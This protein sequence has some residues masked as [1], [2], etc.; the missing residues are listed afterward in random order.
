MARK[1]ESSGI[2]RLFL[3]PL[4]IAILAAG[5][6]PWWW[7]EVK[8]LLKPQGLPIQVGDYQLG[9]YYIGIF[10]RGE[11]FCFWGGSIQQH[12]VASIFED[13]R[14][15]NVYR[16]HGYGNLALI[17]KDYETLLFEDSEYKMA[18]QLELPNVD[19]IEDED[20]QRCLESSEP[21]LVR[22]PYSYK[23]DE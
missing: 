15:S 18:D 2:N 14:K 11:R 7:N 19:N 6:T 21:F 17:Q 20:I 22:H 23:D 12:S 5:T 4:F 3:Y 8:D 13:P 9:S 1:Q 16:I 10:K